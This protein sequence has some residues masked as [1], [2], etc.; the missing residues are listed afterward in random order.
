MNYPQN[1][2]PQ[3]NPYNSYC[4]SN[5]SMT[6]LGNLPYEHTVPSYA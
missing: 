6:E 4:V 5:N 1:T 3:I 2:P